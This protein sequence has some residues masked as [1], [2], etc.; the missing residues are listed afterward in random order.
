MMINV[1]VALR[2]TTKRQVKISNLKK[3]ICLIQEIL[4]KLKITFIFLFVSTGKCINYKTIF[5]VQNQ[6]S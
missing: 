6:I 3:L 5:L 1:N 4:G 2:D